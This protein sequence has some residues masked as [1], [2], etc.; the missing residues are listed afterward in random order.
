MPPKGKYIKSKKTGRI[1][2]T[3]DDGA[4]VEVLPDNAKF[5]KSKKTNA[6]GIFIYLEV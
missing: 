2:I 6:W 5:I 1:G 3:Y 4:T